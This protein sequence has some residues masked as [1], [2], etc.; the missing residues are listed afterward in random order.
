MGRPVATEKEVEICAAEESFGDVLM[1]VKGDVFAI[2]VLPKKF[3]TP[4]D[5]I[6]VDELIWE[7]LQAGKPRALTKDVRICIILDMCRYQT[8]HKIK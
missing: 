3:H 4:G 5:P 8:I 1:S 6:P 2:F 7:V